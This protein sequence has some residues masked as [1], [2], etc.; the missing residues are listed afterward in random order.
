M[1]SDAM[2]VVNYTGD[3]EWKPAANINAWCSAEDLGYWPNDVHKCK[4]LVGFVFSRDT[5]YM[6]LKVMGNNQS[7]VIRGA[8]E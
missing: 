6:D 5:F 3:V 8:W 2:A 7:F 1:L 4:L